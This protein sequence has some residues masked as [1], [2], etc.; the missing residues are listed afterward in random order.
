VIGNATTAD[1][2]VERA[3]DLIEALVPAQSPGA[4]RFRRYRGEGDGNFYTWAEA[5][6]ESAFRRVDARHAGSFSVPV[7]VN[8]YEEREAKV[9]VIIAYANNARAGQ[10]QTRARDA[11]IG[12]DLDQIERA[13]GLYSRTNFSAP[14]PE[15]CFRGWDCQ[16]V[17][18]AACTYL[19]VDVIYAFNRAL[20]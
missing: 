14:N 17:T 8:D 9:T 15:A 16:R 12:S 1:A 7:G 20:T 2:I 6:P 13:I 19:V 3:L 5:N 4:G 11:L 18:Q 10:E